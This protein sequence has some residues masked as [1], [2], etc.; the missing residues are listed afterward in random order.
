M[1]CR[2]ITVCCNWIVWGAN[3]GLCFVSVHSLF[4]SVYFCSHQYISVH[5]SVVLVHIRRFN[6]SLQCTRYTARWL[7]T[8]SVAFKI[9]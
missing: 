2:P 8:Y 7:C 9:T 1:S 4:T 5:I 3:S 6:Y